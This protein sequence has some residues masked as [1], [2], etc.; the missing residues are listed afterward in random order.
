ML[1]FLFLQVSWMRKRDLHILTSNIF[2]YTGD[3]RF[4]VVHPEDTDDWNLRIDYVQER[5][6][7][8]YECQV[9]TEPKIN[10]ALMLHAEGKI[11]NL[12]NKGACHNKGV[13]IFHDVTSH[14]APLMTCAVTLINFRQLQILIT[15]SLR[16]TVFTFITYFMLNLIV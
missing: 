6:A 2:T 14:F 1:D 13:G 4:S 15:K 7:G 9:N 5:D 11:H 10:L 16:K 3:A 12:F 8:I